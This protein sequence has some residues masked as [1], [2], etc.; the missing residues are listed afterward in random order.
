MVAIYMATNILPARQAVR[1]EWK[2]TTEE[3]AP[4]NRTPN[5][6]SML[7]PSRRAACSAVAARMWGV[8]WACAEGQRSERSTRRCSVAVA[9]DY[10]RSKPKNGTHMLPAR[11][12]SIRL[13]SNAC[14]QLM[15][16]L[17]F[18]SPALCAR[19]KANHRSMA[20]GVV[21]P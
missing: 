9:R 15:C 13:R 7:T 11:P 3:H 19:W 2:I 6:R 10:I 4:R 14:A 12:R 16:G 5:V 8:I 17:K 18:F 21:S 1:N 20:K